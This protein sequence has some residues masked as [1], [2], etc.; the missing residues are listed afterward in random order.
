MNTI[1]TW[2]LLLFS[3]ILNTNA[4]MSV[5]MNTSL[6]SPAH[7]YKIT[8]AANT[9]VTGRVS[10]NDNSDLDVYVYYQ[11]TNFLNKNN[12]FKAF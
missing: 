7:V 8:C 2:L 6:N 11:G 3:L 9:Q 1:I 12:Y 5:V 4:T 10:W